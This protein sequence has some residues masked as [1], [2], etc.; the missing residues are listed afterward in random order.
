MLL[1]S[2]RGY[3]VHSAAA[4]SSL[5]KKL[6]PK[7]SPYIDTMI[8]DVN[9]PSAEDTHFPFSRMFDWFLGHSVASGL[10][11]VQDGKNEESSS[12]DIKSVYHGF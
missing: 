2:Y 7:I 1:G 4:L 9:N 11:S 12:E 8:R 6:I 10:Q 3:F 5:D